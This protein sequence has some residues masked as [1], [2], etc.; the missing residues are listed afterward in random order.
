LKNFGPDDGIRHI[1]NATSCLT[2]HDNPVA[3]GYSANTNNF[4]RRVSKYN[5]TT[6][7]FEAIKSHNYP[8][9]RR[10]DAR[11]FEKAT[12][13]K[14]GFP[15]KA[16]IISLRMPLSLLNIGRLDEIPDSVFISH[17]RS[18]GDGIQG[19]INYIQTPDGRKIGRYGWKAS[20]A[21]LTAIVADALA[22]EIGLDNPYATD[23]QSRENSLD[24]AYIVES[25]TAY[26]KEIR[27]G[28]SK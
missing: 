27:N 1:F 28:N 16:N 24:N 23:T 6:G 2:C 18:K 9:A 13:Q 12:K 4:V 20:H 14:A 11:Q 21:S 17:A 10:Y 19:R 25:I 3:G 8:V 7:Q 22:I 5:K 26:L 15:T